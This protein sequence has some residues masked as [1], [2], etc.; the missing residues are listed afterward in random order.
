MQ[1]D[2]TIETELGYFQRN[3][4]IE[5]LVQRFA[6]INGW[7]IE[8][9]TDIF[10]SENHRIHLFRTMAEAAVEEMENVINVDVNEEIES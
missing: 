4:L 2:S 5:K 10:N 8:E 3:S 9:N 1:N 7:E 6:K